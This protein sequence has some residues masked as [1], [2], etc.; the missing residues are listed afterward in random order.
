MAGGWLPSFMRLTHTRMQLMLSF[1]AGLMLGVGLLHMLPHALA[2]AQDTDFV[3]HWLLLGLLGM[4]FMVRIF[5][6]HSHGEEPASDHVHPGEDEHADCDHEHHLHDAHGYAHAH[7]L[8]WLGLALGL[9]V[10]TFFDGVALGASVIAESHANSPWGLVGIGTFLA[11]VLH[12]PLDAMSITSLMAAGGWPSSGRLA[13]NAG[14]ALMCP[15]GAA[16]IWFGLNQLEHEHMFIG[17][18][19]AFSAGMFLCISLSDL[20][21]ELKF[22][23]HDRLKLSIALLLGIALAYAICLVE[24]SHGHHHPQPTVEKDV[25]D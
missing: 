8:S 15:W 24:P 9:A 10:H 7:R 1:V 14:F 25:G 12:K 18:A 16:A 19:L 22:H 4:F 3:V 13:V 5:H 20:L 11:I 23:A 6:F 21:P 2:E 17:G